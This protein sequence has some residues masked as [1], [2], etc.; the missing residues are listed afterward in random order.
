MRDTIELI[1][2]LGIL[3]AVLAFPLYVWHVGKKRERKLKCVAE[4]MKPGDLC[5]VESTSPNPFLK[6]VVIYVRI[7]EIR[8]NPDGTPWVMYDYATSGFSSPKYEKL[9]D[10][11]KTY[12]PVKIEEEKV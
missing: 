12:T 2:C 10:F 11:L 3:L 5:K 1:V 9:E 8:Y 7:E 4:S 6:P